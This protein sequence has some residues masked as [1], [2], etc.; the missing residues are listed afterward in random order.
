MR[1]S[2]TRLLPGGYTRELG[3]L[4]RGFTP[5]DA[6]EASARAWTSSDIADAAKS[7]SMRQPRHQT[8]SAAARDVYRAM[9]LPLA[10]GVSLPRQSAIATGRDITATAGPRSSSSRR[11]HTGSKRGHRPRSASSTASRALHRDV[12]FRADRPQH[13]TQGKSDPEPQ[14]AR[15]CVG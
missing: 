10:G 7:H 9:K 14:A 13:G 15:T 12:S 5:M 8:H 3:P 4:P 6:G 1:R 2:S 11:G